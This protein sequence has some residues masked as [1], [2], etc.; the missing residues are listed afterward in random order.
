MKKTMTTSEK[1]ALIRHHGDVLSRTGM[2][3]M[4]PRRSDIIA[5]AERIIDLIKTVPKIELGAED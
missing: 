1:F 2:A 3:V 4:G 5:S